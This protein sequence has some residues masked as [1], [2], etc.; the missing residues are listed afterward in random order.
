MISATETATQLVVSYLYRLFNV[1]RQRRY[2][3]LFISTYS[4]LCIGTPSYA[5]PQSTVEYIKKA[6]S[7]TA[8]V[9]LIEAFALPETIEPTTR[10]PRKYKKSYT[11]RHNCASRRSAALRTTAVITHHRQKICVPKSP[12]RASE[13]LIL[14][15][16]SIVAES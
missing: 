13:L 12:I 8:V 1:C 7:P 9:P 16:T 4:F 6:W 10:S 2:Q 11:H 15:R 5:I 14:P 3:T